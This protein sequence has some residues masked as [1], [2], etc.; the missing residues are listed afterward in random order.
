[1]EYCCR[2][3]FVLAYRSEGSVVFTHSLCHNGCPSMI[4]CGGIVDGHPL[5]MPIVEAQLETIHMGYVDIT[6]GG[7]YSSEMTKDEKTIRRRAYVEAKSLGGAWAD[8]NAAGFAAVFKSRAGVTPTKPEVIQTKQDTDESFESFEVRTTRDL[9]GRVMT[10]RRM[11]RD[12]ALYEIW[13]NRKELDPILG[14][15]LSH[16]ILADS[17]GVKKTYIG[18]I[19]H[20][21]NRLR[22]KTERHESLRD[23]YSEG[24]ADRQA[25]LKV[26]GC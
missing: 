12:P 8:W 13:I 10:E 5:W 21:Q 25:A 19:L 15:K 6:D 20:H 23:K 24:A 7:R 26:L 17:I 9:I 3:S 11:D 1:M 18:Q 2:V 14:F 16:Q 22:F 4:L